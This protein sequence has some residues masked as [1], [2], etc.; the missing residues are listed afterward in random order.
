MPQAIVRARNVSTGAAFETSSSETGAYTLPLPAAA[1]DVF[2]NRLSY[3]GF[4]RRDVEVHQG[5]TLRIDVTLAPG[6]NFDIPG[7]NAFGFLR[8]DNPPPSGAAPRTTGGQPDLSG[9]WYP[10]QDVDPEEP[11]SRPWA[12]ALARE[13]QDFFGKDDPRTHCLPSGVVRT[14]FFDLTKFIQTRSELVILIEGSPPGFR[15]IFLDGRSHPPDPAPTWMGHSIGKWDGD[16]LVIDTVGFNDRGWIDNAG[17]PQTEQL[18]VIERIH[19]PDLGHLEIEI[20][21][22]DP[23]AYEHP[24]KVRRLL[25][26]A[27]SEEVQEY[28]CNENNKPEHLVGK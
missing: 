24:W 8:L 1:Y 19:R 15:Q 12:A 22:D 5:Q 13:R 4:T 14:N 10:G 9:V 28:V 25:T 16:T 23:G 18:H 21:I 20:T 7:E 17:R 2:I 6:P 26:L 27:A 3:R 11:P